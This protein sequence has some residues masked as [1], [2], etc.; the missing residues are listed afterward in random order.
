MTSRASRLFFA[1]LLATAFFP[2]AVGAQVAITK[3]VGEAR[4]IKTATYEADVAADGCLTSLVVK[5]H[6][7][8]KPGMDISRGAY[9]YQHAVLSLGKVQQPND[10]TVVATADGKP[11]VK[12]EFAG[13]SIQIEIT[14]STA[15]GLQ[16]VFVLDPALNV[17]GGGQGE[18][19]KTPARQAW[20]DSAWFDGDRVLQVSGATRIWGPWHG[21][22]NVIQADIAPGQTR[23]LTVH[24][25][26]ASADQIAR[27]ARV[28]QGKMMEPDMVLDS[29]R[30][31]QVFQRHTK[32]AGVVRVSGRI[33]IKEPR[34]DVLEAHLAGK[35]AE[36][37]EL[38]DTWQPV[39]LEPTTQSF[40][41][42]LSAPAGGWYV[43]EVRAKAGDKIIAQAK[44][45]R[46][47][48]GEVF[49]IAGQSN[50]TNYGEMRL[51]SHSDLTASFDGDSWQPAND[52]QPGT[53]DH[54]TGGSP[55]PAFADEMVRRFHV[56][57]AIASTG[58][59]GT[60]VN[61]WQPDG[62]LFR[63][64][65]TRI[66]QLGYLGF[67]AVLWHQ[68]ESDT[69]MASDEYFNKLANVIHASNR[70]AGWEFPWFVAQVSYHSPQEAKVN[71]TRD[72][73]K[74]LWAQAIALEGPDTDTLTGDNRA[75]K[76]AD[77]HLSEKGLIAHGKLWAEK[78]GPWLE[79][80][81]ARNKSD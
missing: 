33:G 42:D 57:I 64:T 10:S 7:L 21:N 14:N 6:N 35:S 51:S 24:L 28:Q 66:D 74:R 76:G 2:L 39:K 47:G 69:P 38:P 32:A 80:V 27:V 65:L 8:L 5:G 20:A 23:K 73:Q 50:S 36:G 17:V 52:P 46:V 4:H 19:L 11:T 48:V 25:S 75:N 9:C 55:W 44:I 70:S 59:G 31:R 3:T 15:A 81:L 29:P 68:G 18:M 12:Y 61:A 30:E 45:E 71:T 63:H 49:V 16:Y 40:N 58:H 13:D 54:S 78:V 77:I 1:C 41:A 72:A 43:L 22:T 67:R 26:L 62:E 37:T 56:P 34:A 53:H 60:S 79:K